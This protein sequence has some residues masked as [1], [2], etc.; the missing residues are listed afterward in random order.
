M[1]INTNI[2]ALMAHRNMTKVNAGLSQSLERLSS[3]LRINSAKDDAAGLAVS[4]N[5]DTTVRALNVGERNIQ[6]GI[7]FLNAREGVLDQITQMV[8]R[9]RE[10]AVAAN[11]SSTSPDSGAVLN[12]EYEQ[13]GLEIDRLLTT[14]FNEVP[15]FVVPTSTLDVM[16]GADPAPDVVSLTLSTPDFSTILPPATDITTPA[17]AAT[18]L[19]LLATY[20]LDTATPTAPTGVLAERSK[21]GGYINRLEYALAS[22]QVNRENLMASYSRVRDTDMA[23]EM[24]TM[25]KQ[26][27][28][29]QTSTAMLAQAN[30]Q[31]QSVLALFK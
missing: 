1:R 6:D 12:A 19:P 28:I 29:L 8:Q 21:N 5:M 16:V 30:A 18:A 23:A 11:N 20:L 31:P 17:Q 10:L 3:G 27:I 15:L 26:Q 24:T 9:M 2:N 7:A 4:E 14:T 22:L 13:L 25:T